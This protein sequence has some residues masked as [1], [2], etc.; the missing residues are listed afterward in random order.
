MKVLFQYFT[1]YFVDSTYNFTGQTHTLDIELSQ[2]T[3]KL[4]NLSW[5][6][7]KIFGNFWNMIKVG[8]LD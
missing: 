5:L 7:L 1:L 6:K 3:F 8:K 4:T 2:N